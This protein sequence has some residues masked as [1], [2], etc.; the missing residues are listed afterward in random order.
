MIFQL[1]NASVSYKSLEVLRASTCAINGEQV[2]VVHGPTGAGKS[3]LLK[4][5]HADLAPSSGAVEVDGTSTARMRTRQR[6]MHRQRVGLVHQHPRLDPMLTTYH[7]ILMMYAMRGIR[8]DDAM[9]SA[10]ELV[11]EVGLSHCKHLLPSQLSG[12]ER[13]LL[14]LAKTLA[15]E[16][17][18][19]L[20]DEP[21][22]MI[23]A[24]IVVRIGTVLNT[25]IGRGMGL[26]LTTHHESL[27]RLLPT[28]NHLS[29]EDGMLTSSTTRS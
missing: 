6:R 21:T 20:A 12:G 2:N 29:L 26:V 14:G 8:K 3:T 16:P 27:A 18:T 1:T 10:L 22:S 9:R 25:R 11:A 7:N 28:A 23:D 24:G 15:L 17:A 4:L 5:L 13:Q 19:L